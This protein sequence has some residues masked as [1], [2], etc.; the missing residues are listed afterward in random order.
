[1][2]G[3][4]F[5]ALS[6]SA[7][8]V[9][10]AVSCLQSPAAEPARTTEPVRI[11]MIGSL[12]RDIPQ[13]TVLAM[14]QPLGAIMESQTGVRGELVPGGTAENVGKQLQEGKLQLAVFHGI[15]FAWAKQK[16]PELRPLVIAINQTRY[17]R[18]HVV[19]RA[20]S[21]VASLADLRDKTLALPNQTREHCH[22]FL[23][24]HCP[25]VKPNS[26]FSKTTNPPNTEEAL[27]DIIDGTAD[28]TVV[29]GVSLD[30]FKR[31][32]PGRAAK[33]R[34]VQTSEAFP[35]AVVAY[36]PGVLDET[37][38]KRFHDGMVNTSHTIMG[39]QMLTLW[40]LTGFEEVPE[41]YDRSLIDIV[42]VYPTSTKQ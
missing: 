36:R 39:R 17:L 31:R 19:V 22:I 23:S 34:I 3:H 29:D 14:M 15:E 20:D 12:F 25:D 2:L 10:L 28:A 37:I 27:D 6:A 16:Y 9:C 11:G 18:A 21:K 33:L 26:F 8:G 41:D 24:R 40:K 5:Q 38:L 13:S 7:L 32:K 35:A 1:M 30:C 4:T 42:K